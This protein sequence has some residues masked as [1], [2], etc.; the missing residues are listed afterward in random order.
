LKNFPLLFLFPFDSCKTGGEHVLITTGNFTS[1]GRF[2]G[3]DRQAI[4]ETLSEEI[5]LGIDVRLLNPGIIQVVHGDGT[6]LMRYG[7]FHLCMFDE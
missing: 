1:Y 3:D 7:C 4:Y 2:L 5:Q 6:N